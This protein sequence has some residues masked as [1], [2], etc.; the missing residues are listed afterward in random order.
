MRPSLTRQLVRHVNHVALMLAGAGALVACSGSD[1]SLAGATEEQTATEH[2]A[3]IVNPAYTLFTAMGG[4]VPVCFDDNGAFAQQRRMIRVAANRTWGRFANI[5]FEGWDSCATTGTAKFVKI[6]LRPSTDGG[7]GGQTDPCFGIACLSAP[8]EAAHVRLVLPYAFWDGD[9]DRLEY[10]AVHELGH[11]LGFGHEQDSSQNWINPASAGHCAFGENH[12]DWQQIGLWDHDSVMS[13]C[14]PN[15]NGRLS[16]FDRN[17][18]PM[19]YGPKPPQPHGHGGLAWRNQDGSVGTW[20]LQASGVAQIGAGIAAP[21]EWVLVGLGDLDGDGS[22]D[23]LFRDPN[24][25]TLNGYLM[26]K[27]RE[28]RQVRLRDE[29]PS[30]WNIV[31]LADFDN[32][33]MD[34]ILW[35]QPTTGAVGIWFHGGSLR[36]NQMTT[37]ATAPVEWKILGVG[38]FDGDHKAD[39]LWLNTRTQMT[40][41]WVMDGGRIAR[42]NDL[43][44]APANAIF[45]AI[46]DANGDGMA[47][48]LWR[49]GGQLL[50]STMQG[51]SAQLSVRSTAPIGPPLTWRQQTKGFADVGGD[52]KADVV[53]L[54]WLAGDVQVWAL[55]GTRVTSMRSFASGVPT[56]WSLEGTIAGPA[57]EYPGD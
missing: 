44:P 47:D 4:H 39:I 7:I 18:L 16:A 6:S 25:G 24:G 31:T 3:L 28:V 36:T 30:D 22:G 53:L 23:L 8:S 20:T 10:T 34:D 12:P 51:D 50:L 11:A 33:G 45:Q 17:E 40:G 57:F 32:D 48:V 1:P 38:D 2:Q 27:T 14:M 54:D 19:V 56:S 42:Y 9:E 49:D 43:R 35:R 26:S 29:S 41:I 52:G 55:D 15:M 21:A 37:V 13:Y 5:Q 46:G